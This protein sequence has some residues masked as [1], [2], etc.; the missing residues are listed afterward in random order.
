MGEAVGW[1]ACFAW[2]LE[3]FVFLRRLSLIFAAL[4]SVPGGR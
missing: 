1:R 4:A 2:I 3:V